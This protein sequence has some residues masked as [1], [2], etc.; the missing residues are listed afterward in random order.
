MSKNRTRASL[1][2]DCLSLQKECFITEE[3]S[4]EK[5]DKESNKNK[6]RRKVRII[7]HMSVNVTV[8]VKLFFPVQYATLEYF[9]LFTSCSIEK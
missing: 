6:K 2:K 4:E 5:G 8:D 1:S 3:R 7:I 9:F